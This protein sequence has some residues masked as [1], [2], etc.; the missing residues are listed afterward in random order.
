MATCSR[1]FVKAIDE[2]GEEREA[3][4]VPIA[5]PQQ[6]VA[7]LS[8]ELLNKLFIGKK[9]QD[10]FELRLFEKGVLL[11]ETSV[12]SDVIRNDDFLII[13]KYSAVDASCSC[14]TSQRHI[15]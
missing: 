10:R 1:V 6:T 7:N 9:Q 14:T 12:V 13:S 11:D 3:V 15:M 8:E 2:L 5:S 4:V